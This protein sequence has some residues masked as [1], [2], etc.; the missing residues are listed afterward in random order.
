MDDEEDKGEG[1]TRRL[2]G[3]PGSRRT[4]K[5]ET[6]TGNGTVDD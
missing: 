2:D 1:R 6:G 5:S 4:E 3:S